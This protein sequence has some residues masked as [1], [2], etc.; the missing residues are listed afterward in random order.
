MT[1]RTAFVTGATGFL[2]RNLLEQLVAANWRV[3]ALHRQ[4]SRIEALEAMPVELAIGDVVHRDEVMAA[5]P[6]GLDAVFHVAASTSMWRARN[7]E[8]DRINIGGTRNVADAALE[9][10][11]RRLIQTSSY[12]VYGYPDQPIDESSPHLGKQEFTNYSR[13]KAAAEDEVRRRIDRGLDAVILNPGNIVGPYDDHNWSRILQMVAENRLPGVPPGSGA[14]CHSREVARAHLAAVE[15]GRCGENYILAGVNASYLEFV[16]TVARELGAKIPTRTT[17]A[18][19]LK[20]VGR[21]SQ[22]VSAFTRCEPDITPEG[23]H[24]VCSKKACN[25]DK[26]ERELGYAPIVLETMVRDC[27]DWLRSEGRIS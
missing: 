8:Q 14:F 25:T 12:T 15:R 6:D 5:M 4:A 9:R 23:A 7:K 22:W 16:Q 11:A 27:A 19:V 13:S 3:V 1:Q 21:I 18:A 20:T 26:A 17:P 24:M 2:G 10:G